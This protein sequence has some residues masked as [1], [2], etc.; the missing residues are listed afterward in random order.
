MRYRGCI[1][2]TLL[3]LAAVG[4]RGQGVCTARIEVTDTII[5]YDTLGNVDSVR[6]RLRGAAGADSI[7]WMPDTMFANPS[8][9]VQWVTLGYL[10]TLRVRLEAYYDSTNLFRWQENGY[11]KRHTEYN[12][13]DSP[14]SGDLCR[15]GSI[16]L[17]N[18]PSLYCPDMVSS[19]GADR[20]IIRTD[21]MACADDYDTICHNGIPE[22][23]S[24]RPFYVDTVFLY[25][26]TRTHT[27]LMDMYYAPATESMDS[28]YWMP[29]IFYTLHI[30]DTARYDIGR[31][32]FCDTTFTY[33]IGEYRPGDRYPVMMS[34]LASFNFSQRPHG[35]AVI[36]FYEKPQKV[37]L[38]KHGIVVYN[39]SIMGSCMAEDSLLLVG[40]VCRTIDT[41]QVYDTIVENQLPWTIQ[42]NT[43]TGGGTYWYRLPGGT[44]GCD[45]SV[46][47]CLTVY[48]NVLDSSY[49]FICQNELPY[50]Q[51]SVTVYGDSIFTVVLKGLHGED[52]IVT[53][54]VFVIPSTDT[55]IYDTVLEEELPRAFLDSLFYD[56]VENASVVLYNEAGC[57]STIHYNLY[58]FWD[59]D[60]CDSSL[61]FPTLVTPNGDGVNDCFVIGGLLENNCFQFN[62]LYVYDRT[63][64]LIHHSH[65][66][67]SEADWWNPDRPRVP[68][69]TYFYVFKAHGVTIHTMRQGVVE[70]LR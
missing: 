39:L 24:F 14:T 50:T 46:E 40:P 32:R 9:S 36:R 67:A 6:Y 31:A 52:S 25:D 43:M 49:A 30:E 60:H 10:D 44:P 4:V 70:I 63:G 45:T 59:G 47:Y 55:T 41:V 48:K 33:R 3:L 18:N 26:P 37:K 69:A 23:S 21:T 56:E 61:T 2:I 51:D 54:H 66:I 68:A 22:D 34:L 8:S 35:R 58:V 16:T 15:Q 38:T 19:G 1:I 29:V 53:H 65:N 64:Q 20:I 57:D 27:F 17:D 11:V 13:V 12:Y 62:D 5:M 28:N 7:H 42:G